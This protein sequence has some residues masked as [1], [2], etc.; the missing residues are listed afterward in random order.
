MKKCNRIENL[1]SGR[2]RLLGGLPQALISGALIGVLI[3][4]GVA[5]QTTLDTLK[6]EISLLTVQLD[7]GRAPLN[8]AAIAP[9]TLN[10][11]AERAS[12]VIATLGGIGLI[13]VQPSLADDADQG[14]LSSTTL[15]QQ[16]ETVYQTLMARC[17]YWRD[18]ADGP[19][20]GR[21]SLGVVAERIQA[22]EIGSRQELAAAI[23][24]GEPKTDED[25]EAKLD[26]IYGFLDG[27]NAPTTAVN[28]S[29]I[30]SAQINGV[31]NEFYQ[32][33]GTL[34]PVSSS[35]LNAGT[36]PS[37]ETEEGVVMSCEPI[38]SAETEDGFVTFCDFIPIP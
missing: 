30:S 8:S 1:L 31:I 24:S 35:T 3:S 28:F 25:V 37:P 2:E 4:S 19:S 20:A 26:K 38:P 13:D 11:A 27:L 7:Q 18:H 14:Q 32:Q 6:A 22:L 36:L 23:K 29:R 17:E 16:A 5:A 33:I 34:C 9:E 21:V 15:W 10:Q 12:D